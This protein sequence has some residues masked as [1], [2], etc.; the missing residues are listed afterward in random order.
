MKNKL[1]SLLSLSILAVL[2][3]TSFASAASLSTPSALPLTAGNN[4]FTIDITGTASEAITFSGLSDITENGKTIHFTL[5][6]AIT[7]TGAA[8]TLTISYNVPSDFEFKFGKSYSSTLNAAAS[9]GNAAQKISFTQTPFYT[10]ANVG[11]LSI[12]DFELDD[13]SG[14]GDEDDNL[15]Y[16]FDK[17]TIVFYVENNGVSKIKDIAIEACVWDVTAEK[18]VFDE[19]DMEISN[20]KFDLKEDKDQKVT[21]TFVPD[22]DKLKAGNTNYVLYIRAVGKIDDSDSVHDEEKTGDSVSQNLEIATDDDFV[23]INNI[24]FNAGSAS[25]G[26]TVELTADV[27]NVGNSDLEDD[28]VFVWVYNKELGIDKKIEFSNGIDSM[29]LEKIDVILNIPGNVAEKSYTIRLGAYNDD[30]L[31]DGDVF[32]T[33]GNDEKDSVFYSP[34]SVTSCSISPLA[35]VAA[36]LQSDAKVGSE[37]TVKATIT[38]TGSASSTFNIAPS[39]YNSWAS[40]VSMDKNSVTLASGASQDVLITFKANADASGDQTFNIDLIEGTKS[41]S[42]PVSVSV[43]KAGISLPNLSSLFSGN[44]WVWVIGALN[45]LLVLVIIVVAVKVSRKK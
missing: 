28:E 7:A 22:A 4:T 45:A 6:S 10:G 1:F 43:A 35:S 5:P 39:G 44:S 29:E 34:L 16:P 11:D 13:V 18:C 12:T 23:I 41:L 9:S 15:L 40:L 3:L 33:S 19:D 30:S 42:Q 32:Q 27:W 20:D 36:S 21:L 37:F 31:G 25:C 38:N 2:V 17:A 8:Q 24:Q 14:F 26:N